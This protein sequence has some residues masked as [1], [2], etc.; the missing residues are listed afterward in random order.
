MPE[1]GRLTRIGFNVGFVE[2]HA[3]GDLTDTIRPA[4][5][6]DFESLVETIRDVTVE[7]T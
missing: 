7:D 1:P 6:E 3:S 5:Q 4:R 2:E